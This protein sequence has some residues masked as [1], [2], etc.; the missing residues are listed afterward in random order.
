[1][2]SAFQVGNVKHLPWGKLS[3]AKLLNGKITVNK[4][5]L[6]FPVIVKSNYGSRGKGNYKIDTPEAYEKFIK[7]HELSHYIIEEYFSGTREYRVHITDFGPVYSLRKLL[8]SDTPKDKRWV[9]NDETCVWIVEYQ[10]SWSA[11]QKFLGFRNVENPEFDK[12]LNWDRIV[13]ECKKALKS[14]GLDIGAV[15]LKVQSSKD[16]EGKKRKD[17]D[18]FIIEINSAPSLG[19]I[20]AEVY[21]KELPKVLEHKYDRNKNR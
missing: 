3:E 18:F 8:K 10:P 16:K 21:K 9:R 1:M 17:P 4:Q 2:K 12:P 15:D 5:N 11:D 13:E 19:R 14:V 7:S 6:E 20:T